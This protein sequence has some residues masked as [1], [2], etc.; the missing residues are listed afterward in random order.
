MATVSKP[1]IAFRVW[2][3]VKGGLEFTVWI[4][5]RLRYGYRINR[6]GSRVQVP[7]CLGVWIKV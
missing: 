1:K 5:D 3:R 6:L 7:N 2:I 4:L